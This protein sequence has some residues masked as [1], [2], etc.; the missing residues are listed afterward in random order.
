MTLLAP[1]FLAGLALLAVP[2]LVHLSQRAEGEAEPFPSLMFL[3]RIPFRAERRRRIRHPVLFA[4]RCLAVALLALAFARPLLERTGDAAGADGAR[5]ERVVLLDRSY[6]MS[7]G[8]TWE[9]ARR[10]ARE[11]ADAPGPGDRLSLVL[12]SDRAEVVV[13]GTQDPAV[14]RAAV[15]AAE[16]G[17]GITR[18]DPAVRAAARILS[19]SELP[20]RRALLISD[21]Q[22]TGRTGGLSARLPPGVELE[23]ADL[24]V[25]EPEN[26]AVTDL[27]L[28]G[29]GGGPGGRLSAAVRVS[30]TGV[31][32]LRELEVS[33]EVNGRTA[34]VRRVSLEPRTAAT[35]AFPGLAFPAAPSRGVAR[36]G[37]DPLAADDA[38]HFTLA[39]RSP[40]EVRLVDG[41]GGRGGG[42]LYLRRALSIGERPG[43]RPEVRASASGA[44]AELGERAVLL[45]HGAPPPRGEAGRALG[46]WLEAG[47]GLI[48]ALGPASG[49]TGGAA[50]APP[51]P[52]IPGPVVDRSDG[53]GG[54]LAWLDY[55]HPVFRLFRA[56]RSGD[57]SAA[58][59]HRYRR[60]SPDSTARVL[61]RFDDGAPALVAGRAGEGRVLVW[62]STLDRFWNDL[63]LQPV[64][65]PFVQ[66]LVLHAADHREERRWWRAGDPLDVAAAVA[67]ARRR[68]G[69][70]A[71]GDPRAVEGEWILSAP[72]GDRRTVRTGGIDE[73]P[74]LVRLEEAGF[75]ELRPLEGEEGPYALAVNPDTEESDLTAIEPEELAAAV[76]R[77]GEPERAAVAGGGAEEASRRELWP[78]FLALAAA[79]LALETALGNRRSPRRGSEEGARPRGA[80]PWG[81]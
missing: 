20:R 14:F 74:A 16:P 2:L 62:T 65:L 40:L 63:A 72:S 1:L 67:E 47:G 50:T 81:A 26:A 69:P 78:W 28:S 7:Y 19:A 13:D 8:D 53:G 22:R 41:T 52:G 21:L 29:D 61:A 70:A 23:A 59:F 58:R 71:G 54:S 10:A 11:A 24:S 36:L 32:P 39:P 42:L 79:L 77:A 46:E 55:D 64:F 18:Y 68:A 56:P 6:S 43:F 17:A 12:F 38:F 27:T 80:R 34:G 25:P 49:P 51:L 48:V 60:F 3:R 37:G 5:T 73:D 30:N 9:R 57:F 4:L 15:D 45:L 75:H 44:A 76:V 31:R 35:V 66:R 33:L